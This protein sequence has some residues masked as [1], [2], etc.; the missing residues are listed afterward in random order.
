MVEVGGRRYSTVDLLPRLSSLGEWVLLSF[1]NTT[2]TL[3]T[4]ATTTMA[5]SLQARQSQQQSVSTYCS[6]VLLNPLE[7]DRSKLTTRSRRTFQSRSISRRIFPLHVGTPW[8]RSLHR[9]QCCWS[10][11]VGCITERVTD[12]IG[13][14]SLLGLRYWV[15][16]YELHV[17]G[18][19]T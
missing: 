7:H 8:N 10:R 16:V 19:R 14:F 1:Y 4:W 11:M 17:S 2:D 3:P 12:D 18:Q 15:V 5:C 13:V 6:L 9:S